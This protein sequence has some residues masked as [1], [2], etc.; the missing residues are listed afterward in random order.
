MLITGETGVGKELVARHVHAR[1]GAARRGA[2]PRQLRGAAASRSRRASCSGTSP[3]PSPAP[4]AT[5]PASSRSPTA[6]RSSSTRSASCR[7]TL[8]PKLLRALQ[9]GEIQRVG[10]RPRAP[11]RRARDRRDEPRPRARGRARAGSARTST[12]ASRSSRS[13]CRRC[14]SGARTSRCWP[15]TSSTRARAAARRSAPVRL[16]RGGAHAPRRPPTG[17]ATCASSR[18][19]SAGRCCA[20]PTGRD[21]APD[22]PRRRGAP[23]RADTSAAQAS[24]HERAGGASRGVEPAA[25]ASASAT[26]ERRLIREALVRN[27]GNWAAAARELGLHRSNLHHLAARLGLR[28]R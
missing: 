9:E 6:A 8:Q 16:Q 4:R 27:G 28:E 12:T 1:L 5:A 11:R 19:W 23:R 21:P 15:R 14:A 3:A 25:V 13:T 10:S 7:S 22:S 24:S 18:T 26:Y 2:H 17:R 20:H